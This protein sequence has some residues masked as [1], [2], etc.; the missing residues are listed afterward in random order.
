MKNIIILG[1]TGSI[2]TQTLDIIDQNKKEYCLKAFSFGRNVTKAIEIINKY[3]SNHN[4]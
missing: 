1:A 3:K 2:G 4:Y